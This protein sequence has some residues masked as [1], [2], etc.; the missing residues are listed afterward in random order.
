MFSSHLDAF[1]SLGKCR[2]ALRSVPFACLNA[3]AF[4]QIAKARK[5]TGAMI[6]V[7]YL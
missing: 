3:V 2:V 4:D 6:R 5:E 1:D 7:L